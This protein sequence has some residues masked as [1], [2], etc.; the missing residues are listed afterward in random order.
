MGC[1]WFDTLAGMASTAAPHRP[2]AEEARVGLRL[3]A[4]LHRELRTVAARNDRT[5]SAECRRAIAEHV[6]RELGRQEDA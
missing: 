1:R 5:T 2:A 4:E 6:R 3:P